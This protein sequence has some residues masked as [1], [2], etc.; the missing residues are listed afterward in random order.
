VLTGGAARMEGVVELAEE[1]FHMPVRVGTPQS[2]TGL[3]EVVGN[4]IHAT[5]VGLLLY[6]SQQIGNTARPSAPSTE[7]VASV[8]DRFKRWFSGEF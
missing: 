2:V 7:G 4:P 1:M 3:S 8:L 6:G 5:G